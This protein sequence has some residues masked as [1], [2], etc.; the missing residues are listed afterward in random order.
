MSDP[1]LSHLAAA[2]RESPLKLGARELRRPTA[3]SIAL[4]M[5]LNNPLFTGGPDEGAA[6]ELSDTDRMRGVL[7]FVW[8]HLADLDE[9]DSLP[10]DPAALRE[11]VARRVRRLGMEIGFEDLQQF[12]ADFARL[13][14]RLDGAVTEAVETGGPGKP[15]QATA[16]TGLPAWSTPSAAPETPPASDTSSGSCPSSAPSN[17]STPP[18][19]MP[20]P[21]SAGPSPAPE[22]LSTPVMPL[23]DSEPCA[24]HG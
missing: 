23:S 1:R 13:R 8:V 9:I 2:F 17:T 20:A 11:H 7:E 3:G 15:P 6:D 24:P 18:T 19:S 21:S 4:L 16:P 14:E 22:T 10:L 12:G 5:E